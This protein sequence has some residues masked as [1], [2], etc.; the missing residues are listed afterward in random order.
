MIT[1]E[2]KINA[3]LRAI[4]ATDD[5]EMKNAVEDVRKILAESGDISESESDGTTVKRI[6]Y[7]IE[8]AL[9]RCG[10]PC[11]NKG[12]D[13]V[14]EAILKVV[15]DMNAIH[16]V[17]TV[18]YPD[19]AKAYNTTPPRVER[20][21]RHEIEVVYERGDVSEI[22]KYVGTADRN[23]GKARNSEFIANFARYIRH[24]AYGNK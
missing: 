11:N 16:N 22:E 12:Y 3:C 10:M 9:I 15:L 13:Y 23:I 18:L 20:A 21:I 19:I 2:E 7:E 5:K 14:V 8:A 24:K 6:R 17:T 4:A 1:M